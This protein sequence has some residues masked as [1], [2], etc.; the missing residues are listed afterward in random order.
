MFFSWYHG[1]VA[2]NLLF[3]YGKFS[4]QLGKYP[5]SYGQMIWWRRLPNSLSST[6]QWLDTNSWMVSFQLKPLDSDR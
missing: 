3:K 1:E 2:T 4:T 6:S 5:T